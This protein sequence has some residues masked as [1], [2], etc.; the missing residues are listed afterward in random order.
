VTTTR[1]THATPASFIASV[2][3]RG[4]ED[5]IARQ[6][7]DRGVDVVLGGGAKIVT[8]ELLEQH[9]GVHAVR[10]TEELFAA[11]GREDRLVGLF[12]SGHMSYELDRPAS[13]PHLRDMSMFT[14]DRLSKNSDGFVLQIEGGRVDHGGHANDFPASLH[15]QIAFDQTV[16]AVAGWADGRDD[17]LVIVTTDHGTG[18]PDL[19]VYGE[20]SHNGFETLLGAKHTLTWIIERVRDADQTEWPARLRALV[21]EHVGF[22]L[23]EEEIDWS[24]R[25]LRGERV[26]GF[27]G[28]NGFVSA[29]GAVMA[30]HFGVAYCS[31][32]H[33]AEHVEATAF[34]PG[35]EALP[36]RIDNTALHGLMLGA[37]GLPTG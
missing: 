11:S 21:A 3:R 30:N 27:G 31:T 37:L 1:V 32:N 35:A 29:L 13:E 12:T 4:M 19:T 33:T 14:I 15:D 25:P 8:R 18:A 34:G 5:E 2:P 17:T 28:A 20:Q 24:L 7:L 22:D 6:I 23:S 26:N 9:T 16:A 36:S 10:T